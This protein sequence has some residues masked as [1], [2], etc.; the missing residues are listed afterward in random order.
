MLIAGNMSVGVRN[1]T[2]GVSSSSTNDA[3]TKV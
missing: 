1:S 2:N 3:T